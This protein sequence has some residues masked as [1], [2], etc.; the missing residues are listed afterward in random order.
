[1]LFLRSQRLSIIEKTIIRKAGHLYFE[2]LNSLVIQVK[3]ELLRKFNVY[4]LLK[5]KSRVNED[6][7]RNDKQLWKSIN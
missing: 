3:H 6:N 4:L 2:T 7:S 1:V 5:T